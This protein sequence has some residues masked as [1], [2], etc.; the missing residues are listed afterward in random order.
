MIRAYLNARKSFSDEQH[1]HMNRNVLGLAAATANFFLSDNQHITLLFVAYLIANNLIL[2]LSF[3]NTGRP[4]VRIIIATCLDV[5]MAATTMIMQPVTMAFLYPLFLWM[6]LGLGFRLGLNWLYFGAAMSLLAFSTVIA[7]TEYWQHNLVLGISLAMALIVIPGYCSTLIKKLSKAKDDAEIAN[8]AKSYFLASVSHELRTPLNAIIGYGNFM[9]RMTLPRNQLDMVDA[10]VNAGE[11]LLHLIDQLIEMARSET[12]VLSEKTE[13]FIP[14][15]LVA[16]IRS[17]MAVRAEEK[18]IALKI[19]ADPLSDRLLS[20]PKQH[21]RNVL[22]NLVGNAIKF[23]DSGSVTLQVSSSPAGTGENMLLFKVTDTGIGI[24]ADAIEKI[25]KP[26]Q[27]ADDTVHNRFGGSGLGLAICRQ[28]LNQLGGTIS[29]ESSIGNGSAFSVSVPVTICPEDQSNAA[30]HD[31]QKILALGKFESHL[32]ANLQSSPDFQIHHVNCSGVA[33]LQNALIKSDL[34]SYSVAILDQRLAGKIDPDDA[35]WKIFAREEVAP[36]LVSTDA[37]DIDIEDIS[38]RAAFASVI[39]PGA[40]Y[41]SM[42]S[43]IRIGCSFAKQ[44]QFLSHADGVITN[45]ESNI[46]VEPRSILVADDNR[47]NRNVLATIL[48]SSGHHV[49]LVCDGDEALDALEKSK[50]DILLLDVNMPRL[51]GIDACKMWRLIEGNRSHMPI[52]GVTADATAETERLCLDAG[53]DLRLTKPVNATQLLAV[54]DQQCGSTTQTE[55]PNGL[56]DPLAKVVA[57]SGET[58]GPAEPIDAKQIAYLNSIGDA[59]FLSSMIEGFTSDV[60]EMMA[61]LKHAVSQCEVEKFRFATHGIKSSSNNIGAMLLAAICGEL[62]HITEGK[63]ALEK[64]VQLAKIE[65]EL[66][67]AL[68]AL[69]SVVMLQSGAEPKSVRAGT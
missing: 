58:N 34:S 47:T 43:A 41:D 53:M 39:P 63:F 49:T 14:T 9:Q 54:I 20:G 24:G 44:P 33:D 66:E 32:L 40:N 65:V 8:R 1:M 55:I 12:G 6:T 57:I 64:D 35:I 13:K 29:V 15:E 69:N 11:H 16:E 21:I 62:E 3:W 31:V 17:I 18:G 30:T 25:F 52:V 68:E 42:R 38:L 50:F 45:E 60:Q 48:Q 56:S 22:L 5:S 4:N 36:V 10:S 59:A 2:T 46:P 19:S 23:T 26:F 28:L 67:R 27:Q 51:N 37:Q 7:S 61:L